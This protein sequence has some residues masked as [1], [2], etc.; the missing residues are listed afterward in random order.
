M[1]Q[2]ASHLQQSRGPGRTGYRSTS[3]TDAS[4]WSTAELSSFT[5]HCHFPL[6]TTVTTVT[7]RCWRFYMPHATKTL[8]LV[9]SSL[10]ARSRS[11]V[12]VNKAAEIHG[13]SLHLLDVGPIQLPK[14]RTST[15]QLSFAFHGPPVSNSLPSTCAPL[16]RPSPL[17]DSAHGLSVA[18]MLTETTILYWYCRSRWILSLCNQLKR[19]NNSTNTLHWNVCWR[20]DEGRRRYVYVSRGE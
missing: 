16:P 6:N 20:R 13:Y 2:S 1:R 8:S 11:A 19:L 12:T 4:N 3:P 18:C 7:G 14:V 10:N 15:G 5:V 17:R 9:L